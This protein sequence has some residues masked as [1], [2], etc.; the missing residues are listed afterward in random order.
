MFLRNCWY[1][2][3]WDHELEDGFL[4]RT[5]LDE[6]VVLFRGADG[7]PRALEDRCCHRSMPLSR[8]R[9]LEDSVQC[10]YHGLEFAFDGRCV[11]V[12]GQS[13][14]PPGARVRAWPVVERWRWVWIWMGDP[15][16]ADPGLIPDYHWNDD[17]EWTSYGDV[18]H[19]AGD[20]RLMND[21]LLDL[22]HIQFLHVN[23]LG[24]PGDQEA[25]IEVRRRPDVV[26]VSRWTFDTP[27]SPVLRPCARHQRQC[28]PLAERLFPPAVLHRH[29]RRQRDRRFGRARGR[30]QPRRG[31][32]LE[33]HDDAGERDLDAL[34]L[35]PRAQFPARRRRRSPQ[36][37][38]GMFSSALRED[39]VA[40]EAQQKSLRRSADRPMIDINVDNAAFQGRRILEERLS[41]EGAS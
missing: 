1:V 39:T 17:P 32:L 6:P 36:E 8:G 25:E 34:F 21:N 30:P 29:R 41:A 5:I 11:K 28:R 3:A 24:A 18:Y 27:P 7:A 33:P 23:T 20:Y 10:G 16:A 2:A 31:G 12:P 22:S 13:T 19:V 35:A 15:D 40:I 14:I 38:H 37:L 26:H 9:L 4:A